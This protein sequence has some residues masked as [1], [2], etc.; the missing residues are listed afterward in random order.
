MVAVS[1]NLC[2]LKAKVKEILEKK[3]VYEEELGPFGILVYCISLSVVWLIITQKK[4][5]KEVV[6]SFT[7]FSPRALTTA[8][9]SSNKS[10]MEPSHFRNLVKGNFD[11]RLG[12]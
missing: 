4:N 6:N 9:V 11:K 10:A 8:Q 5:M 1:S 2:H 7:A 3:E 12:F